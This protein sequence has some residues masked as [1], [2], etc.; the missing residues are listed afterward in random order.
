MGREL[1]HDALAVIEYRDNPAVCL[2]GDSDQALDRMRRTAAAAGCRVASATRIEADSEAISR[3]RAGDGGP[4]R[5][6]RRRR[7]S[8]ALAAVLDWAAGKRRRS[9]RRRGGLDAASADRSRRG[10]RLACRHRASLRQRRGASATAVVSDVSRRADTAAPR[11]RPRRRAARSCSSFPRMSAGSR[12]SS[13]RC[14]RRKHAAIAGAKTPAT[15]EGRAR[16][17]RR[18]RPLDHPGAAAA[19]PVLPRRAVR[20]SGLGHAARSDG[21][22]ARG[23]RV[24]VSSLCIAAAVPATTA[25]R[26]IKA[27]T[28]RGLFVRA[29]D[30]QDGRRVYIELV[31][32]RGALAHRLSARR[33]ADLADRDLSRACPRA[34]GDGS[35]RSEGRLAQLVE[36]LVYTERVGGSSPSAPTSLRPSRLRL[37]SQPASLRDRLRRRQLRRSERG[38][39]R[40]SGSA[41]PRPPPR[42]GRRP[43]S[44]AGRRRAGGCGACRPRGRSGGRTGSGRRGGG[45]GRRG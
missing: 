10:A 13:P 36:H 8:D 39:L 27:L 31:R 2:I 30:P 19:R 9:G 14:P 37:A 34:P 28:D 40:G 42:A 7:T 18:L 26:W 38:G 6:G 25:L 23:N 15:D 20:R 3:L 29:A 16:D 33:P 24:A 17:R 35:D 44:G 1:A 4:D 32:R 5:A 41:S 21:G 12:R 22:A 45:R 11:H 43:R